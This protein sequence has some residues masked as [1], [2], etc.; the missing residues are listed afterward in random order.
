[1]PSFG[2]PSPW[3]IFLL[4]TM[5]GSP[6]VAAILAIAVGLLT[7]ARTKPGSSMG[8]PL[9]LLLGAIWFAAFAVWFS[10]RTFGVPFG[11]PYHQGVLRELILWSSYLLMIPST[12]ITW[13]L[14]RW[15]AKRGPS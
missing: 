15:M 9:S 11:I 4:L 3:E 1:M 14:I 7:N 6:L 13:L 10:V 5:F 8:F 12:I 2:P